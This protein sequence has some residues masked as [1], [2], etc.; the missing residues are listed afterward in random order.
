MKI[1]FYS[2]YLTHHQIPFSNEMYHI[3]NNDYT[4]ISTEEMETERKELGWEFEDRYSYE[5]KAY[6]NKE[7]YQLAMKLSR[8]SDVIL[9]GSASELFVK[10]R[11]RSR[12]SG[13]TLRYSERIYKKGRWRFLSPRGLLYRWE[14]YFKYCN[15]SLYML[16]AS[17]YT[18]GDLM[19][20]GSYLGK[21]YKWGYFP[22]TIYYN[23]DD[24][25]M[26][27]A[28]D[29]VE[30]LWCGRLLE[31]KHPEVAI[32]LALMLKKEG[33]DFI[34]NMIGSGEK[35]DIIRRMISVNN[36]ESCVKLLGA[37]PQV[38]VR[39]RMEKSH[40]FLSTSDFQE[41]W[42]A[43]VNEAMNSGCAVVASHA[44]GSVPFLIEDGKNGMV[45]KNGSINILFNKV[46][47]LILNRPLCEKL[48][49]KAYD[50]IINEWNAKEA[51]QRLLL[52]LKDLEKKGSSDRF[53]RGPCSKAEI[54]KNNWYG[55]KKNESFVCFKR[56]SK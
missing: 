53:Q 14:T 29:K 30:I 45:Y 41:G 8:D 39:R 40:I 47:H 28:E 27:K 12:L 24:L 5:L 54:I 18:S 32:R 34:L 16:C 37:M 11:M 9:V 46:R 48:G 13:L 36:L 2:N 7:G 17:A 21:C 55:D 26:K 25:M 49:R 19:L 31:W 38:Q 4:F 1:S 52:L 23:P 56:L 15:R 43:V 50:T 42:G 10:E 6:E 33:L 35:E 3:L 22:E 20:Q 44:V 51:V